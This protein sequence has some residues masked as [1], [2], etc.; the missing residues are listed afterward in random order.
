MSIELTIGVPGPNGLENHYL[1]I[2]RLHMEGGLGTYRVRETVA[3][4]EAYSP[5]LD[6]ALFPHPYI[7]G[8]E[9]CVSRALA[10]LADARREHVPVYVETSPQVAGIGPVVEP[11]LPLPTHVINGDTI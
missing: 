6:E 8:W 7:E 2:L 10:A 11:N 5:V 9:K 4:Y 1:S 3:S